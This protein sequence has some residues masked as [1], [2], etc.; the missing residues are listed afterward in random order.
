[1][2]PGFCYPVFD[3]VGYQ[4]VVDTPTCVLLTGLEAV[5]P[6][7][8]GYFFRM[9]ITET[10]GKAVAEEDGHLFSFLVGETCIATVGLRILDIDLFVSY[11]QVTTDYNR[12]LGVKS[13]QKL[14]KIVFPSHSII[15]TL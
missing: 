14:V 15:Q 12:L 2:N 10:V 3:A 6:P 11:I 5:R 4:E 8:I 13:L 1:M 9:K 7:R